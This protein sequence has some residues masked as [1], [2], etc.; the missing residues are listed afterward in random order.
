MAQFSPEEIWLSSETE[1]IRLLDAGALVSKLKAVRFYAPS[2]VHYRTGY[3]HSSAADFPTVSVTGTSC[4][5]NCKHCE[6]KVLETMTPAE[7]PAKLLEVAVKLK[8][9]GALGFLVSG[10]CLPDGSVPLA[11]FIPALEQVK[12]KLGLTVFVHTGII[13]FATASALKSA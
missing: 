8:Q 3:Y 10:G 4:A 13:D 12:R 2:F 6:G 9:N 5:L 7:T 11:P 1:F